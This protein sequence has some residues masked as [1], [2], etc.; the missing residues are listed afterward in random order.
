MKVLLINPPNEN[1]VTGSL[2]SFITS[3]RGFN[4]PLGLLYLAGYLQE[5]SEHDVKIIDCQVEEI[6]F[7]ELEVKV[8]EYMPDVVGITVLTMALIDVQ[9]TIG[10]IKRADDKIT[11]VLGGPHVHLYPEETIELKG[12]DYVVQ[13]EGEVVFRKLLDNLDNKELLKNINGLVFRDDGEIV[14]TRLS[15]FIEDIDR[16]PFPA[17][18]LTPYRK[19]TSVLTKEVNVTT[20]FT[21]RG[22]P[23]GCT[24]CDRHHLGKKFR[25]RSAQNVLEEI[26]E[27]VNMGIYGFLFYDDTFTIDKQRV[28]DIC[29]GII[30]RKLD[31]TWNIRSR[32]DTIDAEMLSYLK[33]A[34]C[35]G[36]N[37]GVESGS[38]KILKRLN[39]GITIRKVIETFKHTH[40][41]GIQALAYFMI[42]NPGEQI[43]N[44][45]TTF[46][47]MHQLKPDYVH[48][49]ILTPLPGTKLYFEALES[50][51][52][53]SDCWKSFA[54]NPTKDFVMPH[55][56]EVFTMEE[57]EVLLVKGYKGFYCRGSYILKSLLKIRSLDEFKKKVVAGLR[58]VFSKNK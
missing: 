21:S 20:I 35:E 45:N 56:P 52:I 9:M 28:I 37:Y 25:A 38:D 15:E 6:G 22:C 30:D 24:F 16:L 53:K 2:P 26:Q 46:Q 43:E 18:K 13:G 34:G 49:T 11:V 41:S 1:E 54:K 8:L 14:N 31:I 47:V 29:K 33:K 3:Q 57:L 10:A 58:L 42:G 50:N 32:V 4:P 12:V 23:Y 36:I 5:Y 51:V 40:E 39:K 27:C 55:W 7:E 19:Y 17:R 48:I 44:I